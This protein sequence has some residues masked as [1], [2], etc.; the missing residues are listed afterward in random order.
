MPTAS[1]D[2]TRSA[3]ACSTLRQRRQH[4]IHAGHVLRHHRAKPSVQPRTTWATRSSRSLHNGK[5]FS[6]P[7]RRAAP[8]LPAWS[9]HSPRSAAATWSPPSR[10]RAAR[11]GPGRPAAR[12]RGGRGGVPRIEVPRLA[13]ACRGRSDLALRHRWR[14][15]V[16]RR[17]LTRPFYLGNVIRFFIIE[18]GFQPFD[19]F[20][21]ASNMDTRPHASLILAD[22]QPCWIPPR[23]AWR[24]AS[25]AWT[26]ACWWWPCAPTC[27]AARAACWT[28]GSSSS[29]PPST[30]VVASA[31]SRRASRLG[32]PLAARRKLWARRSMRS[33][34]WP[35][36][37]RGG[38]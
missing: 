26:T 5:R 2:S 36:S 17:H 6:W 25:P 21:G 34:R 20:D 31:R 19:I 10:R 11:P 35:T 12:A 4:L 32:Q 15:P 8:P 24:P 22:L 29:K 7:C 30:S 23:C 33:S 9:R 38:A 14:P 13:G 3:M 16:C 27:M 1:A 18:S 28:G 37:A